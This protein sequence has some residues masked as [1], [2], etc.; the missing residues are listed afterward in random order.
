MPYGLRGA[1]N[2]TLE[3]SGGR[4]R[5][6]DE[7]LDSRKTVAAGTQTI[8]ASDFTIAHNNRPVVLLTLASYGQTYVSS[9]TTAIADGSVDGQELTL[10]VANASFVN[11][12]TIK[13]NANTVLTGDW[14]RTYNQAWLKV[15]WDA[16]N[17]QW[18]EVGRDKGEN[19]R[20]NGLG[21]IAFGQNTIAGGKYSFATG[22]GANA[23]GDKSYAGGNG[24]YAPG[25]NSHACGNV[26]TASG[27][28]AMASGTLSVASGGYSHAE[29]YGTAA[30]GG[31]SH[32]EGFRSRA[33]LAGQFA[34][35]CGGNYDSQFTRTVSRNDTADT[36]WKELFVDGYG[37]RWTLED[38]TSYACFV[39][40]AARM[41]SG[42]AEGAIFTRRLL[43]ERTN[44]TVTMRS[45]PSSTWGDYNPGG[46]YSISITADDVNKSLKI[47]VKHDDGVSPKNVR[48]VAL[49]EA[50][51]VRF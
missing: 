24:C 5:V 4:L 10:I 37:E 14:V 47:Q 12:I 25:E 49:V 31:F 26:T 28:A 34:H 43:I 22:L 13:T 44:G 36:N 45:G 30:E 15:V 38:D 42:G 40:I 9:T 2:A 11:S 27:W 29:G 18:T 39:N 23:A 17:S 33:R 21:S 41:D 1:D 46:A 3:V 7:G 20:A 50:V 32:A 48:W 19:V 8:N 51:E 16:G 6:K 35:A